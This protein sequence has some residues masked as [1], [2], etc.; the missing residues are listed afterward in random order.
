MLKEAL[1]KALDL[2]ASLEGTVEEV[3]AARKENEV[4]SMW[5]KKKENELN[6]KESA[7]AILEEAKEIQGKIHDES[8]ALEESRADYENYVRKERAGIAK[9]TTALDELKDIAARLKSDKEALEKDKAEYREVIKK[10]LTEH[11]KNSQA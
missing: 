1:K 6:E 9:E 5:L 4:A 3:A 10:K 11:F 2:V 7:K 8:V